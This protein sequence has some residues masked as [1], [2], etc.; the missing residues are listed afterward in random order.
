MDTRVSSFET[1]RVRIVYR[2]F[3]NS[4]RVPSAPL[5]GSAPR[6]R[7]RAPK[8]SGRE[9]ARLALPPYWQKRHLGPVGSLMLRFARAGRPHHIPQG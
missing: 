4:R 2:L 1:E 7:S 3:L 6:H 5:P 9:C 8:G